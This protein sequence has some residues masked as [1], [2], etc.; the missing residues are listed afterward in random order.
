M[1]KRL[2][3]RIA[4]L[5]L[6]SAMIVG[7]LAGCGSNAG[8]TT[9][10]TT[11]ETTETTEGTTEAAGETA[12][13]GSD[14]PLVV[15]IS[16]LSSKF[17]MFFNETDYDKEIAMLTQVMLAD[18]DRAG[19]VVFNGGAEGE[20]INYNGTDYTY[21]TLAN[22]AVTQNPTDTVYDFKLREDVTFS[23]GKPVTADDVI[24]S[25]YVMADPSYDGMSTFNTAPIKGMKNYQMNSSVASTITAE[26]VA[27]QVEKMPEELKTA[28][29]ENIVAPTLTAEKDWC[30][31]NFE[32]Q[33]MAS[34]EELF[35]AAYSTD[36]KYDAAGKDYDTIVADVI[37]MYGAD[38]KTLGS[39]YAGDDTYYDADVASI[40]EKSLVD[41]KVAAGEGEEVPSIE[42]IKKVSDYEVQV[43]TDGFSATMIYQFGDVPVAPLH[44]YG[45]AAQYDYDN[46]KFGFTRGD[47]SI[48]KDK[49]A[50]P[51]GAGPY[52]FMKYEN[53]IV[54][55]EANE[56]YYKGAPKVKNLQYKETK[57]ADK[58]PGVQQGTIDLSDPAGSKQAFEQISGI[59]GNGELDGDVIMTN[60][61]D[62]LGYGYMGL[63]SNTI[64][65]GGEP[66]S[67]ASKN[68]R[69]AIATIM[70]VYRDVSIDSYYGDAASVI[71]YPISNTSWAAPQKSDEGYE[72]AYSKDVEGNP[73]YTD[74]MSAEDK[75]AKAL[76]ASLGY[77]EAA[78]YTVADGKLTAAPAG[79]KLT[80]EIIIPADGKG[81]HPSFAILTDA[82]AAFESIGLTLEINDPTDSNILWDKLNANTQEM[83]V[84]A[85]QAGSDPDMY[86]L[87]HSDSVK[88]NYYRI[89]DKDLD[90]YIMDAR[91]NAD[92]EYR[93]PLYKECMNII[94][95][96]AVE[97]PVYQRQ[98]CVIYSPE[99]INAD[100]FT[101]DVTTNYRW[102]YE[103]EKVEV[104]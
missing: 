99:R 104:K 28:I 7:T 86:Q 1:K 8:T 94:M 15:G 88:S 96:W 60:R 29:A 34:A 13:A 42:G 48:V 68:L 52:K 71:N 23:D 83:W 41:A 11:E 16:D 50:T 22:I 37:A 90:A 87:Y 38:Y 57:D 21:Q 17:S 51:M 43:T 45:D 72:V 20:V 32:A 100:T 59:N 61:V 54:Y 56:T 49:T 53:K 70:A 31:E 103:I 36:E 39:N 95:D 101:K 102:F 73:I 77:F 40:A 82:K 3:S 65:V 9:E 6:S 35:V 5:A 44:Y 80:Y 81:D 33:G 26:D 89:A 2:A 55:Y 78:G 79:A 91:T 67:E 76:E 75:Y 14:K 10:G 18:G 97:I 4:A 47:L 58:I 27:A 74:G 64:N 66:A 24:F 63:N 12:Q 62:N 98:N 46:N 30:T 25:L 92:Q 19:A 85:W 69:K 93:K 84:A